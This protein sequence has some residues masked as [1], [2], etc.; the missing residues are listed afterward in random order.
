MNG[1]GPPVGIIRNCTVH[2]QWGEAI[3]AV[4]AESVT[5]ENN[6]AWSNYAAQYYIQCSRGSTARL[7]RAEGGTAST[8][9][10]YTGAAGFGL[11]YDIEA[12]NSQSRAQ[13]ADDGNVA[14]YLNLVSFCGS[15]IYWPAYGSA[16]AGTPINVDFD[17]NTIVDCNNSFESY[18]PES[19]STGCSFRNNISMPLTSAMSH[20]NGNGMH[21]SV[22]VNYNY[23]HNSIDTT[24]HATLTGA[25]DVVSSALSLAKT[26]GWR[27]SNGGL[28]AA[29]YRPQS[30]Q[31]GTDLSY[32]ID[33]FGTQ[34]PMDEFGAIKY[35][36]QTTPAVLARRKTR[37]TFKSPKLG[38]LSI[39]F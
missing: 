12:G 11:G 16:D 39:D 10:R 29:D 24:R 36:T 21:T 6:W 3:T 14:F 30:D 4:L 37:R 31:G 22:T 27:S 8:Y 1:T 33:Y 38:G 9:H 25:N 28:A 7:N 13:Q 26:S 2:E 20:D 32:G 23:W 18:S 34:N 5:I 17:H 35:V 19:A 15:G